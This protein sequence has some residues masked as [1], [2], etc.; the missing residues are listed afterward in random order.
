MSYLSSALQEE[1]FR[2]ERLEEQINDLTELHQ[3]EVCTY[4]TYYTYLNI[5]E[6]IISE[7]AVYFYFF[8]YTL[9]GKFKASSR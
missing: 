3:N 1:R 5:I 6:K 4:N 9:G 2:C 7:Y 8:Y